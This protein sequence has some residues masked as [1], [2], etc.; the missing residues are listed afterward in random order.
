MEQ[1]VSRSLTQMSYLSS[2]A[3][4][5]Q[6]MAHLG[7]DP[8]GTQRKRVHLAHRPPRPHLA[9]KVQGLLI[10]RNLCLKVPVYM[11]EEARVTKS[12]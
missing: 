9:S 3:L 7:R 2:A 8:A 5:P 12:G 11:G 4:S 1:I 6:V 10:Q